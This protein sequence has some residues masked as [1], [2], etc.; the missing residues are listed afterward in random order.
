VGYDTGALLELVG[1]EA[2]VI[3]PYGSD[4]SKL[5]PANPEPL[6]KSALHLLAARDRFSTNARRR[7]EKLFDL[8]TMVRRYL[9]A[10]LPA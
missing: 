7:A 9:E 1:A 5:Q 8:D 4:F 6:A 10:L 2:G 3:Q